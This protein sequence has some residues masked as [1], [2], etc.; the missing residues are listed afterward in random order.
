MSILLP[1]NPRLMIFKGLR[2]SHRL[3]VVRDIFFRSCE[4][5]SLMRIER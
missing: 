1:L 2:F 5:C 3:H 4:P